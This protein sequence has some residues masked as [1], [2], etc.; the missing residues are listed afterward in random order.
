MLRGGA[1]I[2]LINGHKIRT[3]YENIFSLFGSH[4]AFSRRASNG[5]GKTFA[6]TGWKIIGWSRL[7]ARGLSASRHPRA[8]KG[9][10]TIWD[11]LILIIHHL[12]ITIFVTR[13][14]L[15][16]AIPYNK[17]RNPVA[18]FLLRH[19]RRFEILLD[20]LHPILILY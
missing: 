10:S 16:V 9:T 2:R 15:W 12:R 3:T 20:R 6:S 13:L 8:R 1:G 11:D 14:I 4:A 18:R 19:T 17:K 5:A 7:T